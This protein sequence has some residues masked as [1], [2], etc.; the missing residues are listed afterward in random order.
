MAASLAAI[1]PER[2]SIATM[3]SESTVSNSTN[4]ESAATAVP[5]QTA[6]VRV[7]E[8]PISVDS[9]PVHLQDERRISVVSL[10]EVPLAAVPI[11]HTTRIARKTAPSIRR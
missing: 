8:S 7:S 1:E 5:E 11:Q 4:A 10:N 6:D 9:K 3:R 2:R